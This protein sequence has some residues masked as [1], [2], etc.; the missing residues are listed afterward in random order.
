MTH[1]SVP[2]AGPR[3]PIPFRSLSPGYWKFTAAAATINSLPITPLGA[4][5]IKR[6]EPQM[7]AAGAK[8]AAGALKFIRTLQPFKDVKGIRPEGVYG[9]LLLVSFI[10]ET[11]PNGSPRKFASIDRVSGAVVWSKTFDLPVGNDRERF[12]GFSS[13]D[14]KS[15]GIGSFVCNAASGVGAYFYRILNNKNGEEIASGKLADGKFQDFDFMHLSGH[16]GKLLVLFSDG[17]F[18]VDPKLKVPQQLGRDLRTG[19]S[20]SLISEGSF[21]YLNSKSAGQSSDKSETW[22]LNGLSSVPGAK[23]ASYE[24]G[25]GITATGLFRSSNGNFHIILRTNSLQ[26]CLLSFDLKTKKARS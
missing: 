18:R 12:F 11:Q 14:K 7:S 17:I 19:P 6:P 15:I 24:I 13:L 4:A 23:L 5:E 21:F 2:N 22:T 3:K 9:N 10:D 25:T 16:E 20:L 26:T 1:A 8:L